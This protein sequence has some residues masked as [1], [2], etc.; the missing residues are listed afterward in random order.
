V[1]SIDNLL[2]FTLYTTV[3]YTYIIQYISNCTYTYTETAKLWKV[4]GSKM[5]GWKKMWNQRWWPR[6]GCDNS[7]M[8]K[9]LITTMQVNLCVLLQVSL[10]LGTKFTSIVVIKT[11][12]IELIP[13]PFLGYHLW[14]HIFFH[15]S[16]LGLH[17][18]FTACC[19]YI[20]IASF[21]NCIVIIHQS[22]PMVGSVI[23]KNQLLQIDPLTIV[24]CSW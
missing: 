13:Q 17:T 19:F 23:Q 2:Q 10:G 5:L 14:L 8:A 24:E 6:N 3:L 16:I 22:C 11:F 12:A 18:F 4:C 20:N 9:I 7:S 1:V 15:P 21:C